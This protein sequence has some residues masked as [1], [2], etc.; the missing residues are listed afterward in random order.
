MRSPETTPEPFRTGAERPRLFVV[1]KHDARR[2][3]WDFRLELS[4]TLKSWAVPKGPSLDPAEKRMAVHVEDH[5]VEYGDFEG[6]IPPGNY[7]AGAVILWDRGRW[8][9][10]EEP[11]EG[12]R[13]GKLLF[14]LFG[15]K[16]RGVWTLVRTKRKGD[17]KQVEWLLI[18]Q[19]DRFASVDGER[20]F[21]QE[22][23][24]SGLSVNELAEGPRRALEVR[25]ELLRLG[26]PLREV[27]AGDVD[28]MLATLGEQ[29]F[30]APGWVFELKYDGFRVLAAR[31]GGRARLL[32]R[33]G[34]DA[35]GLYPEVGRA[36]RALPFDGLVMDGEV[37]VLD[38]EGR[39]SFQRLQRRALLQRASDI[40]RATV[41]LPAAIFLFDL[42][43]CEGHDLRGLP[44]LA[45]KALLR[46]ILPRTGPL[47][48]A[49]HIDERGA[50]LFEQVGLRGLEGIVGKR[51]DSTYRGGRLPDWV[52]L[53]HERTAD[54]AVVGFTEPKDARN[55]FGALHLAARRSDGGLIY[56]GRVGTGFS[57]RQLHELRALL[58]A[59]R[60]P[61]PPCGG[62]PPREPGHVWVEP[63][64][65]VEVRFKEW[66]DDGVLRQPALLRVRDDKGLE[67]IELR[68]AAPAPP[69]VRLAVDPV[70][71]KKVAFSNLD[72]VFWPD[73]GHTKGDLIAYYRA[74]APWILP[75]LRDRPL[76]LTRYPDGIAGK[77]FFQ[78]DA[79]DFVPG[80]LRTE[81]AW[82][83]QTQREI[84]YFIC[85]DEP[86]LLY[87]INM[88]SIPLHV[89]SSRVPNLG[90]PDWCILDLDPKG[91]PLPD[92][93][94]VAR[95]IH[96]LC[97]AIGLPSF[98][99]TSGQ[100]GLHVLI[101]LGGTCTHEQSK[102]A[103]RAVRAGDRRRA[104]RH[105][106][107][108]AGDR[109]ARRAR[110]HRLP[111]ERPRQDHRRPAVR[112]P[113]GRSDG[114]DAAGVGRGRRPAR[115][116]GLYDQD[117]GGAPPATGRGPAA[118]SAGAGP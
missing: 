59:S 35:A 80:W 83:E 78:K 76:V 104:A 66:T 37:V 22:S 16:L 49:D 60:R 68:D 32:Y 86:S 107:D 79:P 54:F 93:V 31:E 70:P 6:I 82:S 103:R 45:R 47:R 38:E 84:D 46:R 55:G 89:W 111:P 48:Y 24:L 52:K 98:I 87:V 14:E 62:D 90:R 57:G 118:G 94:R 58:D 92:V 39:P 3:H 69:I 113:G 20:N 112:A 4:G 100:A 77:S 11:L 9:A 110:L 64:L 85:D 74:V 75:Y 30:S 71:E 8:V 5:P 43:A 13:K 34:S 116:P 50:E 41:D 102:G 53:R 25:E 108:G 7:G 26:A 19:P 21:G 44:L 95:A 15:Y 63:R 27:R 91:A 97:D 33:R 17:T 105:L 67:E 101:P 65:V 40:E 1:Q 12:M 106:D 10:L 23:I 56:S 109:G 29:P 88:G 18:K 96:A 36:L 42:L 117:G 99:K 51:A 114:V 28:L 72:K 81:R 61:D 73:E 115:P 2:L